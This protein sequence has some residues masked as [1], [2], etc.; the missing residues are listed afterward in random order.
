MVDGLH[1]GHE[2]EVKE[3]EFVI[4]GETDIWLWFLEV[5]FDDIDSDVF[6]GKK[7]VHKS[8]ELFHERFLFNFK[9]GL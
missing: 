1:A 8:E 9:D 5:Q 3:P 4:E 2:L 6:K 7:F